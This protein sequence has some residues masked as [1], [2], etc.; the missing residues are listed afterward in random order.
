M[1]NNRISGLIKMV[2]NTVPNVKRSHCYFSKIERENTE[3]I[4]RSDYPYLTISYI[5]NPSKA[6]EAIW[7]RIIEECC[8]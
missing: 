6:R 2:S 8:E 1:P 5:P 3:A 7:E 4:W